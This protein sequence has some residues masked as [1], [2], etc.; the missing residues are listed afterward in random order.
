MDDETLFELYHGLKGSR[1]KRGELTIPD[2]TDSDYQ[3]LYDIL[4]EQLQPHFGSDFFSWFRE[5]TVFHHRYRV[6]HGANFEINDPLFEKYPYE[7]TVREQLVVLK[8]YLYRQ[9]YSISRY[10]NEWEG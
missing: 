9:Y 7:L 3:A 5:Q 2:F 1:M 6:A 4:V 8:F 10:K